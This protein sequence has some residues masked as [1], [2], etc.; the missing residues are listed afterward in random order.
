[1]KTF[2]IVHPHNFPSDY[3]LR[4]W[5]LYFLD[6]HFRYKVA[7]FGLIAL[8]LLSLIVTPLRGRANYWLY[9]VTVLALLPVS[10]IEQRYYI[11]PF[12]LLMLFRQPKSFATELTLL[13]WFVILSTGITYGMATMKFFI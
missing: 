6:G 9:P 10:L 4:N 3:F 12:T 11:V 13:A 1:M 8:S 7:A 5:L 2:K